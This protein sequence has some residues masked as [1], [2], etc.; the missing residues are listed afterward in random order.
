M[1]DSEWLKSMNNPNFL[2]TTRPLKGLQPDG[3]VLGPSPNPLNEEAGGTM[4][5][6]DA[7]P[8]ADINVLANGYEAT[9]WFHPL[10]VYGRGGKLIQ[11]V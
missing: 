11:D 6:K 2:L 7:Q 9:Q 5:T 3:V 1:F 8:H 10:K 4:S